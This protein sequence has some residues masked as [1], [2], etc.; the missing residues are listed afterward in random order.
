MRGL[1]A[2]EAY[3]SYGTVSLVDPLTRAASGYV[4]VTLI[5]S[6]VALF[7]YGGPEHR[8]TTTTKLRVYF[9]KDNAAPTT[10]IVKKQ[11]IE[12]IL[13]LV[14]EA[15][16][17]LPDVRDTSRLVVIGDIRFYGEH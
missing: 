13:A 2:I 4:E 9:R 12:D 6:G 10:D 1:F 8:D 5:K 7:K 16:G 17:P 15:V 11:L 14:E 3:G